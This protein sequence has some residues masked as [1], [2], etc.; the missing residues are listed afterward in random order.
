MTKKHEMKG[1]KRRCETE[2][3]SNKKKKD[4]DDN[5]LDDEFEDEDMN[6]DLLMSSQLD[7]TTDVFVRKYIASGK[8]SIA[9]VVLEE[10]IDAANNALHST[11]IEDPDDELPPN[12]ELYHQIQIPFLF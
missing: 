6:L 10:T 1:L 3:D 8:A 9:N 12:Q 5:E 2:K 7:T 4:N 11:A